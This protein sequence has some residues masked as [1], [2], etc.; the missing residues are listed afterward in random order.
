VN[1]PVGVTDG[2]VDAGAEL[3]DDSDGE[4]DSADPAELAG[5][6][7]E[8][9]L[10]CDVAGVLVVVLLDEPLLEQAAATTPRVVRAAATASRRRPFDGVKG[11]LLG[12]GC[13]SGDDVGAD[14]AGTASA[15]SPP[16]PRRASQ[17]SSQGAESTHPGCGIR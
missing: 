10:A 15:V 8:A 7:E 3:A 14:R 2:S 5:A 4:L 11:C 6:G 13:G 12:S 17:A 1:D 16:S 9:A